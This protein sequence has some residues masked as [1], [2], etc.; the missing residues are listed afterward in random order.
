MQPMLLKAV[1]GA[2]VGMIV[3]LTG[4]GS[5]VLLLPI[6]IFLLGVPPIVAVG[7]DAA[8]SALTKFG[9][10]FLH[11]RQRTVV[12]GL[13][14][15]LIVGSIPSAFAGVSLLAHLRAAYGAGVNDVLKHVIGIFLVL[16]TLL[17]LLQG[18][19]HRPALISP[20][21]KMPSWVAGSLIGLFTGFI[22]GLTS[23]GSGTVVLLLLVLLTQSS[24]A[25]LV[26][27]D[28][29]HAVVLTGFT[30]ALYV[31]LGTVDFRLVMALLS[32]SIPGALIGARLSTRLPSPWLRRVLCLALLAT[33]LRMLVV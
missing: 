3:G 16:I 33:G 29:V 2:F 7:S 8:F 27:T 4:L 10:A 22:V 17:L 23:V 5:G 25:S 15:P 28:I 6:L 20:Q 19:R 31:K 30:T 13:V 11:W 21:L 18:I 14:C 26:G 9:A 12:W 32:G 1:I 24:P